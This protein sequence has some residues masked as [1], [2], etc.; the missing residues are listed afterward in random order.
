MLWGGVFEKGIVV[1]VLGY[2]DAVG[3]CGEVYLNRAFSRVVVG[4]GDA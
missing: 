3:C 4:Y 1:V 2:G